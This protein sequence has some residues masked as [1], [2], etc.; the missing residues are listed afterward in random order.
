MTC[1][2]EEFIRLADIGA[3]LAVVVAVIALLHTVTSD[4]KLR[5]REFFY[6]KNDRLIYFH[7][8]L[9]EFKARIDE[10]NDKAGKFNRMVREKTLSQDESEKRHLELLNEGLG[11]VLEEVKKCYILARRYRYVFSRSDMEMADKYFHEVG[12]PGKDNTVEEVIRRA[13]ILYEH[14]SNL[15]EAELCN[16]AEDLRRVGA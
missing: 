10:M 2:T 11:T 6:S 3:L 5:R 4:R 13:M 1:A 9:D 7:E 8:K 12:E 15:V 16:V 14:I